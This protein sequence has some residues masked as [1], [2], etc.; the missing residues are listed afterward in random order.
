MSSTSS[1]IS[2]T[3]SPT[4]SSTTN[5]NSGNGGPSSPLLFFVAL[6]FGVVFTNLW[7]IVGVKYCFRYNQRNRARHAGEDP[8]AVDMTAMPRVRRRRE[9]KLMTMDE[10]NEKFPLTKYKTWRSTRAE[11]GLPTAGGINTTTSRP[12]S[13]KNLPRVSEDEDSSA[14][15]NHSPD[16]MREKLSPS[17]PSSP[18]VT[19]HAVPEQAQQSKE[20]ET[21]TTP[22]TPA[23]NTSPINQTI[24]RTESHDD[25]DQ[26]QTA[27][28]TEQLPDPGDTCA[29][30]IDIL[31]DDDDVRGLTCGHAFHASCVDPWLTGRRA[32]CPLCKADYYTPKPRPEGET[33]DSQARNAR[34]QQAAANSRAT[35][36]NGTG[37]FSL[38]G[39]IWGSR[40]RPGNPTNNTAAARDQRSRSTRQR[41][42]PRAQIANTTN[43]PE[44]TTQQQSWR[45]RLNLPRIPPLTRLRG[46]DSRQATQP[47]SPRQLESGTNR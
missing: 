37:P 33:D 36:G 4:A 21:S 44:I 5:S 10:V 35:A 26:I 38:V 11:E 25:G 34:D 13:V 24:S 15:Q 27:I 47:P 8:D 14:A 28:P 32:C 17:E 23:L 29:I 39:R 9:K 3:I 16:T 1:T 6:G 31:E 42:Q 20:P 43:T 12:G 30:C 45:T 2:S 7:I 19:R 22:S 18:V 41:P 46:E 40:P